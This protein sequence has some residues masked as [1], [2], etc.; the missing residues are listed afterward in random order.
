[1]SRCPGWRG[2]AGMIQVTPSRS[3]TDSSQDRVMSFADEPHTFSALEFQAAL[4]EIS[5]ADFG[6]LEKIARIFSAR[7]GGR[8]SP[9]DILNEAVSRTLDGRRTWK[10]E[11]DLCTH[12]AG[13]MK[14]IFSHAK[15]PREWRSPGPDPDEVG[16]DFDPDEEG[17]RDAVEVLVQHFEDKGNDEALL[18]LEEMAEEKTPAEVRAALGL[19]QRRYETI[20]KAIR[21]AGEQLGVSEGR[22]KR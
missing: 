21:R 5:D 14:S 15:P 1:M 4:K 3:D 22:K 13:V 2:L 16:S 12:L 18:V 20:M 7:R 17:S 11:I 9:G 6:R 19:D 10:R 8:M